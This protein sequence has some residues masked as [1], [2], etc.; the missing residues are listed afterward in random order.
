MY[1]SLVLNISGSGLLL[2]RFFGISV[3]LNELREVAKLTDVVE[4][5]EKK[6]NV[7]LKL[8]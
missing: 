8:K 2:S 7:D 1:Y 6:K 5:P 3:T 4:K